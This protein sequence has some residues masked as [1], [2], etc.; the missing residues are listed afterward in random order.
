MASALLFSG[1][2][3]TIAIAS[4]INDVAPCG[5]GSAFFFPPPNSSLPGTRRAGLCVGR[6]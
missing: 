6:V 2:A 4:R 1:E 3:S 5:K